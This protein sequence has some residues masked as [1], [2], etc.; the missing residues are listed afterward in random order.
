[1]GHRIEDGAEPALFRMGDG[2]HPV[3]VDREVIAGAIEDSDAP[4]ARPEPGDRGES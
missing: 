1:M 3:Q 2:K 4:L